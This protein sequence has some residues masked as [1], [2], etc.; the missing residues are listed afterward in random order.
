MS[1]PTQSKIKS[2]AQEVE[3]TPIT[4]TGKDFHANKLAHDEEPEIEGIFSISN[5]GAFLEDIVFK[6]G[7]I[8]GEKFSGTIT[9]QEAKHISLKID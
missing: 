8:T 7:S 4:I 9:H 5:V 1:A 6:F 2:F 3:N